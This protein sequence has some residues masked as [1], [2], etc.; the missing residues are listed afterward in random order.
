MCNSLS[1]CGNYM[2]WMLCNLFMKGN[3]PFYC[4]DIIQLSKKVAYMTN[5]KINLPPKL[6]DLI[7]SSTEQPYLCSCAA[8][9]QNQA[10]QSNLCSSQNTLLLIPVKRGLNNHPSLKTSADSCVS[11]KHWH[12]VIVLQFSKQPYRSVY[13]F[14]VPSH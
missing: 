14:L 7:S 2:V 9:P 3:L 6:W 13:G 4:F 8:S 12:A 5:V 11:A 10:I 1:N